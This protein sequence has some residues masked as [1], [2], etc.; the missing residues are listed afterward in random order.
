MSRVV[1]SKIPHDQISFDALL[2]INFL[3]VLVIK[4]AFIYGALTC[5]HLTQKVLTKPLF[6]PSRMV[7]G[8]YNASHRINMSMT[9]ENRTSDHQTSSVMEQV[10]QLGRKNV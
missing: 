6:D 2:L 10:H 9:P 4:Y 7:P 5:T 8:K 3:S 1:R